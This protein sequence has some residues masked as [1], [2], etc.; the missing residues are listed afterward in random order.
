MSRSVVPRAGFL[1]SLGCGALAF[2]A[3]V[4]AQESAPPKPASRIEIGIPYRTGAEIPESA[5]ERCRI[6]LSV[7]EGTKG[8]PTVVWFHG[9][10]LTGG[11]RRIPAELTGQGIAIAAAGYRLAP[12]A[13]SPEYVEDAAAAVAWTFRH[14]ERYG[15]SPD[16]IYVAG[17]SAGAYLTLL[18]G[19]DK[20]WLARHD[21]DADRIAGLIP[22]SS[23]TITHFTVRKERGI[24]E[25]QPVVDEMAPLFHVRKDAPP[26]LL[27]TGD[28][29]LEFRGRYE[30]NAYLWR[31]MKEA[32]HTGTLL[33]ELDGFNHGEM[34]RPA[35]PLLLKFVKQPRPASRS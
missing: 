18:L 14:I 10:G 25:L 11:E 31:M 21:I 17:H 29:E 3:S 2:A 24:G 27:I 7:P 32:G 5:R 33:Y 30:E 23:Q 12:Q 22:Y 34:A 20:K 26:M 16:R 13:K 19:L 4:V 28:R 35:H 8:F 9:G 6:D 1:L 15:G